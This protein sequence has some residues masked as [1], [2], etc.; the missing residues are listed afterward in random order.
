MSGR[1]Q[2]SKNSR[3]KANWLGMSSMSRRKPMVVC[4]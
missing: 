1:Y 3:E 2:R 4:L